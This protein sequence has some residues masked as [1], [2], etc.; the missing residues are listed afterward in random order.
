MGNCLNVC[1][2]SPEYKN[3]K[4]TKFFINSD[5]NANNT[6]N[7]KLMNH[8]DNNTLNKIHIKKQKYRYP[9]NI[10]NNIMFSKFDS[11]NLLNKHSK[12][13]LECFDLTLLEKIFNIIILSIN[14]DENIHIKNDDINIIKTLWKFTNINF[15]LMMNV[16]IRDS[17][18][19]K[20]FTINN[21]NNVNNIDDINRNISYVYILSFGLLYYTLYNINI[22]NKLVDIFIDN[23]D[24]NDNNDNDD[25]NDNNDNYNN[26]KIFQNL[27]NIIK[28]KFDLIK[29]YLCNIYINDFSLFIM[30][31]VYL[32]Y[33]KTIQEIHYIYTKSQ[34]LN[35]F[36]NTTTNT[37][38]NATNN[39]NTTNDTINSIDSIN[40][41]N[42]N[43][44]SINIY[45]SMNEYIKKN[46]TADIIRNNVDINNKNLNEEIQKYDSMYNKIVI[47]IMIL[48]YMYDAVHNN[49]YFSTIYSLNLY[50]M[51]LKEI[52]FL[53]KL[54]YSFK[55]IEDN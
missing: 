10:N 37:T 11:I 4:M 1:S 31:L 42:N 50:Y 13:I 53:E 20:L 26:K 19:K 24:N 51:N 9:D 18:Y 5:I 14:N 15:A 16:V 55:F 34:I 25:N 21:T 27:L 36:I 6:N 38:N 48:K 22:L 2:K 43:D 8:Y 54:N 39:S 28:N 32:K 44:Y 7:T 41:I 40:S 49:S 12:K 17:V 3:D 35:D 29:K 30:N 23:N 33:I 45:E 46:M 52:Y 47:V